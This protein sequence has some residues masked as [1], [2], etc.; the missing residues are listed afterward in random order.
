MPVAL[1]RNGIKNIK[2]PSFQYSFPIPLKKARHTDEGRYPPK[3][4]ALNFKLPRFFIAMMLAKAC[5]LP[6]IAMELKI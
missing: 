6:Y 5:R 3:A 2:S 1:Y 4:T